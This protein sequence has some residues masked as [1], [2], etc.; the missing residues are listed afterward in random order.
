MEL[1][2][3]FCGLPVSSCVTT[4]HARAAR[5]IDAARAAWETAGWCDGQ[6]PSGIQ[7]S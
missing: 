7:W 2:V 1:A 6:E 5:W 4:V 3:T